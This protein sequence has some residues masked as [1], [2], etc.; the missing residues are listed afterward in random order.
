MAKPT[1]APAERLRVALAH[2]EPD[3]VPL[4]F[5]ATGLTGLRV[6]AQDALLRYLDIDDISRDLVNAQERLAQPH[7]A[8]LER[9]PTDATGWLPTPGPLVPED[10]DGEERYGWTPDEHEEEDPRGAEL[11][12]IPVRRLTDEW[13]VVWERRGAGHSFMPLTTPL[14]GELPSNSV[15]MHDFP[16][17]SDERRWAD[18]PDGGEAPTI[19][20]GYGRGLLETALLLRGRG[21]VNRDLALDTGLT[22]PIIERTLDVKM[23]YWEARLAGMDETP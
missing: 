8:L 14:S 1:L 23:R 17:A 5:A 13:G 12:L 2:Q 3:R 11:P 4:D 7:E 19:V 15:A 20:G 9:Y 16:D 10:D 18:E 6:E 21:D 22:Q